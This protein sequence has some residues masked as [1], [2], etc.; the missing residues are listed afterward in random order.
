MPSANPHCNNKRASIFAQT[1]FEYFPPSIFESIIKYTYNGTVSLSSRNPS[2]ILDLL[3]ASGELRLQDLSDRIQTYLIEENTEWTNTHFVLAYRT[4]FQDESFKRLQAYCNEAF[5][6]RPEIIF[7]SSDFG[8]LQKRDL[9]RLLRQKNPTVPQVQVWESLIEWGIAQSPGSPTDIDSWS[10]THWSDLKRSIRDA[11][12]LIR[13]WKISPNDFLN[14]V[15]PFEKALPRTIFHDILR[16]YLVPQPPPQYTVCAVSPP[17]YPDVESTLINAQQVGAI[18]N[19]IAW[20]QQTPLESKVKFF[21]TSYHNTKESFVF[22][23]GL[24][25]SNDDEKQSEPIWSRIKD[26]TKAIGQYAHLGPDFGESDLSMQG[27]NYR[28]EKLCFCRQDSYE[29]P[30]MG[31]GKEKVYFSAEDYEVFEVL[32]K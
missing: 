30:I 29:L 21:S 18:A 10:S 11:I 3:L 8:L 25:R 7:G 9:L 23:F 1:V 5:E 13:F 14:K 17:P 32:L 24:P 20:S 15:I 26:S 4:A 19:W 31:D 6:K 27:F 12:P 28:D 22:T 16:H 2:E